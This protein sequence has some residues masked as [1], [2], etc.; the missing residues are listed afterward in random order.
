[1]EEEQPGIAFDSAGGRQPALGSAGGHW[2]DEGAGWLQ[3]HVDRG[4]HLPWRYP[5]P[6]ADRKGD[7]YITGWDTGEHGLI[8]LGPDLYFCAT[9]NI[10]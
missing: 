3:D 4:A 2:L 7:I 6:S 10:S 1:M 5:G 8:P 9:S